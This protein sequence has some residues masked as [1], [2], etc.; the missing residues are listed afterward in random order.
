MTDPARESVDRPDDDR[1]FSEKFA[2]VIADELAAIARRRSHLRNE[3]ATAMAVGMTICP[4]TDRL[5][6]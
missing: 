3:P 2:Y 6:Q 5:T 1:V 4:A